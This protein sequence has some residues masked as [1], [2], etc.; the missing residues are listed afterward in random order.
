VNRLRVLH[1]PHQPGG[2][3]F[4]AETADEKMGGCVS[5][6]CTSTLSRLAV[7]SLGE[8]RAGVRAVPRLRSLLRNRRVARVDLAAL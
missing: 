6:R 5:T 3:H 2:P 1:A 8:V 7:D 4:A